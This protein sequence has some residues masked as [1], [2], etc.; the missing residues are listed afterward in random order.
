MAVLPLIMFFVLWVGYLVYSLLGALVVWL[1]AHLRHHRLTYGRAYLSALY[2]L[3]ASFLLMLVMSVMSFRIPFL[4]TLVLF[5]MALL[6]FERRTKEKTLPGPFSDTTPHTS[7]SLT[8][9]ARP[10]E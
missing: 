5:G 1:A 4:F 8:T 7:S 10:T 9:P 6:N 2:L 3:P